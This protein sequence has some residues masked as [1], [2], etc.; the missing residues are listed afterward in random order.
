LRKRLM[1][2][3]IER[4]RRALDESD[5]GSARRYRDLL[6]CLVSPENRVSVRDWLGAH[7]DGDIA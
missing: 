6:Y 5:P 4:I 3:Q 2:P 1:A 7:G